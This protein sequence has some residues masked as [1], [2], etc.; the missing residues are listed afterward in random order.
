MDGKEDLNIYC[1]ALADSLA[2]V[3]RKGDPEEFNYRIIPKDSVA[4]ALEIVEYTPNTASALDDL[5]EA[6]DLLNC[7]RVVLGELQKQGKNLLLNVMVYD[8][9]TRLPSRHQVRNLFFKPKKIPKVVKKIGKKLRA[10]VLG[11]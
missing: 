9:S 7:E 3:F 4:L 2:I 11:Q 5:W 10:G 8:V 1:D 6:V